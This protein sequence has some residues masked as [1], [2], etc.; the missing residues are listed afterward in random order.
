[1]K[2]PNRW[3]TQRT[4]ID[5]VRIAEAEILTD[6]FNSS[7]DVAELD[8]TFRAVDV[9]EV[10]GHI[11]ESQRCEVLE[12]GFRMQAIRLVET[13]DLIGYFHFH[14]AKPKPDVVALSMFFIRP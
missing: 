12:R 14:E 8:P 1:M 4:R 6:L 3:T 10:L 9:N 11:E 13:N 2:F 5:N 7:S